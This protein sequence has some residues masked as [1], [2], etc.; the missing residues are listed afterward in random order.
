MPTTVPIQVRLD[1]SLVKSIDQRA[2][3]A[4]MSRAEFLRDLLATSLAAGQ[5][6][7]PTIDPQID[8]ILDTLAHLAV[9]IDECQEAS[10]LAAVNAFAAYATSRLY[11]LKSL[12]R[13]QQL[14]FVEQLAPNVA[15]VVRP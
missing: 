11:A 6:I 4:N 7:V 15:K 8:R 3:S 5:E 14:T 12:P 13:D 2:N 1:H 10:E 9:K